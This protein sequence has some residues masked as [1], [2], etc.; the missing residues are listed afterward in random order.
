MSFSKGIL[1]APFPGYDDGQEGNN[2][3]GSYPTSD[4]GLLKI[5]G[6]P[7][8]WG[9]CASNVPGNGDPAQSE[10]FNNPFGEIKIEFVESKNRNGTHAKISLIP[11]QVNMGGDTIQNGGPPFFGRMQ[12]ID[13]KNI[14]GVSSRRTR[15]SN[16]RSS[17]SDV[18]SVNINFQAPDSYHAIQTA[19]VTFYNEGGR[20]NSLIERSHGIKIGLGWGSAPTIFTGVTLGGYRSE[21]AG[22]ETITVNCQDYMYILD[23][24]RMINSPYYD[25]L[26]AFDAVND[27]AKRAGISPVDDTGSSGY[28]LPCGYS[29]TKPAMRFSKSRTLKDC[30]LEIARLAECCIYFDE[31]GVMHFSGI[32]GGIAFSG[33]GSSS[34]ASFSKSPSGEDTIIDEYRVESKVGEAVNQIYVESVDR[35]SG[36]LYFS[37]KLAS[38]GLFDF[39]KPCFISQPAL[40]SQQACNKWITMLS[41]RLFK[42]PTATTIKTFSSQKIVPLTTISV[43]GKPYRVLSLQ[44]SYRSDEN[45]LTTTVSGEWYG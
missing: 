4:I 39:Y 13:P 38:N 6:E 30:I 29:F 16:V 11:G 23:S 32:Q 14:R 36:A 18:L 5:A 33:G 44:R 17:S 24:A 27:I 22:M 35:T 21:T 25:G 3:G 7:T 15:R 2:S 19:E 41:E 26:D 8:T 20:N 1:H 9:A 43:E 34:G 12:F 28:A 37:R 45:S 31:D 40:G 10:I 42:A